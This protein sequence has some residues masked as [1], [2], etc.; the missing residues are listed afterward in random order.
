MRL[1]LPA[2]PD[3]AGRVLRRDV[4]MTTAALLLVNGTFVAAAAL[5][6]TE[7]TP[8]TPDMEEDA[9][10]RRAAKAK[11]AAPDTHVPRPDIFDPVPAAEPFDDA[12]SGA[13]SSVGGSMA[14]RA[15][16]A[17]E[18][19]FDFSDSLFTD[20]GDWF[21]GLRA[22]IAPGMQ[23]GAVQA[24]YL[25]SPSA[26]ARD[27]E[28]GQED[29]DDTAT[30]AGDAQMTVRLGSDGNDVI[31]G[32]GD[33]DYIFGRDGNDLLTGGAG[34]DRLLG[35]RGDDVLLGGPGRDLLV[36]DKGD[37]TLAGGLGSDTFVFRSGFGDDLIVD[38]N[39][40][41]EHDVIDVTRSDF[42]NFAALS[43]SLTDTPYGAMLTLSDGSTLTLSHVAKASLTAGDFHFEV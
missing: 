38:F 7:P 1:P 20:D 17:V 40:N 36:G 24:P 6:A 22:G 18:D 2:A 28:T 3:N 14:G 10:A 43:A 41:G 32:N 12:A 16:A 30:P 11:T 29:D 26:H 34:N 35:G 13:S 25:A 23:Q 19:L 27:V 42:A 31:Q 15:Y 37:D 21:A 33:N 9:P 39:A 5:S 8:D 4:S